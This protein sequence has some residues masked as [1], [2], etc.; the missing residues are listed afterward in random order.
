MSE[1]GDTLNP[2]PPVDLRH[3]YVVAYWAGRSGVW[4][5]HGTYSLLSAARGQRTNL[6]SRGI[7]AKIGQITEW[8]AV[9]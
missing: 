4:L 9:A 3:E 6:L 5:I 1:R 7:P 8:E 2:L